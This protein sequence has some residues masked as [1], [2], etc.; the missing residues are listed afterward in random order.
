MES[1]TGLTLPPAVNAFFMRARTL[2][3]DPDTEWRRI[4][5]ERPSVRTLFMTHVGP[6]AA[7]FSLGPMIGAMLFPE[8]IH[9]VRVTP[10]PLNLPQRPRP[11]AP[12][13]TPNGDRR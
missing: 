1:T 3:L 8:T 10:P 11:A 7:V 13:T 4:A 9:G 12:Q 5:D 2:I 6:L